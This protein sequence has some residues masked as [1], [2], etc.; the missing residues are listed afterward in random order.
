[1]SISTKRL[2]RIERAYLEALGDR[3][4]E[5]ALRPSVWR[6][7]ILPAI[8]AAVPDTTTKEITAMFKWRTR[9]LNKLW[10]EFLKRPRLSQ[11]PNWPDWLKSPPDVSESID[12][13]TAS[14]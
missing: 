14:E 7:E 9:K 13:T 12:G 6:A 11:A 3:F 4:P 8:L 1:M 5:V 10:R 2:E